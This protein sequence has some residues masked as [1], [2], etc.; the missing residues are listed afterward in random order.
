MI[1]MEGITKKLG[2]NPLRHE[3]PKGDGWMIDDNWENPFKGLT[4]EEIHF[5]YEAALADPECWTIEA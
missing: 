4:H 3:Y 5:I 2:F 1:T